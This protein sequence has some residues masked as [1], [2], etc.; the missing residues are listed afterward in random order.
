MEI[1]NFVAESLVNRLIN[2]QIINND[3]RDIYQ[4]GLEVFISLLT[5][6]VLLATIAYIFNIMIE[7][8]IFA[9]T[10]FIL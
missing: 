6:I 8:T 7:M 3:D 1:I 10:F 2:S 4:Y 5:K 9:S